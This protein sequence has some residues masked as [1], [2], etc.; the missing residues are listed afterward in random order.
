MGEIMIA[1]YMQTEQILLA[2][3]PHHWLKW[4][5]VIIYL[6][7]KQLDDEVIIDG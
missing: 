5:G 6:K 3:C 1:G 2:L 7:E 4:N